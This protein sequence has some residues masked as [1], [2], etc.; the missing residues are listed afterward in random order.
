MKRTRVPKTPIYE[1][2]E[3]KLGKNNIASLTETCNW[4]NLNPKTQTDS[5]KC[6]S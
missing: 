2:Y 3:S 4:G 1:N 5:M 6:R